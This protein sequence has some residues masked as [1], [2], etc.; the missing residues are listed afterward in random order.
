MESHRLMSIA[1]L[2]R[3]NSWLVNWKV[4]EELFTL[5]VRTSET[6]HLLE[7]ACIAGCSI[8]E[9]CIHSVNVRVSNILLRNLVVL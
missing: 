6:L 5:S 9:W 4:S 3:I 1:V 8:S 2:K 7:T